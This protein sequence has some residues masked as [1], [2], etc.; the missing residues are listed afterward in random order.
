L[1]VALDIETN[2]NHDVIWCCCTYD[3]DTKEVKVWTEAGMF[4]DFIKKATLIVAHNGISFDFPVLNKVWKTTIRMSQ[5]RDTLVMSRLSN[6][7]RENGHSLK[8]LATLVGREKKEFEDFDSGITNEMIEYCKEDV[9]IC[10]ELYHYLTKELKGFSEQSINLEHEVAAIISRQEK[11]GFKL[12]TVKA[13]CLLGQWKR[14]LSDIEEQLQAVF[15]PIVTERYSE[16]TGKRLKDDVE[17]FNPGSRQQIA[18]RLMEKGWK[19]SKHTDKGA[20]IVDE[21]VLDGVDIP[22]AKLIA[23]YLLIQKRVAQ[24]ESWLEF[25]SDAHR[26]HGKVITNGAVTGR[27]THHSPNMAQVPS[28][29]SPWG[30]ECRDCWT[31]PDDMV[32]V[33]A[34]ASGLELRMLAHYMRDEEYVKELIEGDIHTKNQNAAGLQTRAQAKTFIYALLYGAGPAKIGKIVGGSADDGHKLITTFLRNTPA[35]KALREKVE[36]LSAD[37]TIQGLDGRKLQI[38]ASYAALNTLLQSAGAIVMKKA[39]VILDKKIRSFT[40]DAHFVANVHDEW[41]IECSEEDADLVGQLAVESIKQAGIDLGL[42][43]P[44]DGEYKKGKTWAHTH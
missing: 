4:R 11:H 5:V 41:Q 10:G 33:G 35:L 30:H 25:V 20:V 3:L 28:S 31:V 39:L 44:L 29:S 2:F 18:K 43:C 6:P 8:R 13:L 17:T 42:R 12:D 38:R 22:E 7:Q 34:D 15:P 19:P 23:E 16:K 21:S 1:R 37:G 36:R 9:I 32:L 40:L 26:V 24:V 27:M 14:K